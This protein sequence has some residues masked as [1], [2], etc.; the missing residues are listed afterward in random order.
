MHATFELETEQ[1][2]DQ[3]Q[4]LAADKAWSHFNGTC[5]RFNDTRTRR[6]QN[7]NGVDL[8]CGFMG[9][10]IYLETV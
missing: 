6:W 9:C 5:T 4:I 1:C 3:H 7:K 2:F 8:W 10:H